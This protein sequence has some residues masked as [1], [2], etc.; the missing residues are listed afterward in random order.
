MDVALHQI[1]DAVTMFAYELSITLHP[2]VRCVARHSTPNYKHHALFQVQLCMLPFPGKLFS[3]QSI[4]RECGPSDEMQDLIS[5]YTS[6]P[7][8]LF[9]LQKLLQFSAF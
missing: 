8:L 6:S 5:V 9:A 2:L 3:L 7:A 4:L 1:A